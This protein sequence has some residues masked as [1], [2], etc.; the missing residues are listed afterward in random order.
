MGQTD[1][2]V[3]TMYEDYRHLRLNQPEKS[4]VAEHNV[5]IDHLIKFLESEVLLKTSGYID[6]LAKEVTAIKLLAN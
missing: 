2:S 4:A 5:G 3:E 1:G 6:R